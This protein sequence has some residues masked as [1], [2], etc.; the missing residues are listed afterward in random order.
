[1]PEY[2]VSKLANVLF[3]KELARRAPSNVHTYA[4]HPG[5]VAS[6]AW[7]RVPWGVRHL[8]K[9]FLLTN[10]QGARTTL[11]CAMSDEVRAQ[12]GRY[13]DAC[14]EKRPN[15]LAEVELSVR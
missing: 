14:K 4:L 9:A 8:L 11:Y 7:R 3:A 2:R 5:V 13:Y 6:D 1:M 15:P 10:E 12:S